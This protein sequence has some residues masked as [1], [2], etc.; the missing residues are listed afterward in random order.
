MNAPQTIGDP[1]SVHCPF[2]PKEKKEIWWFILGDEK[3]GIASNV[4]RHTSLTHNTE[5][6]MKF[7]APDK[8]GTYQLT[9]WILTDS[10]VGYNEKITLK[11]NVVKEST[12]KLDETTKKNIKD[13]DDE[14]ALL[15]EDD[16]DMNSDVD[17]DEI[18]DSEE[19]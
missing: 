12:V 9:L 18:S 17:S 14:N 13:E 7:R 11:F 4:M 15:S 10:Y 19:E 8:I 6:Q 3:K 5:I 2:F 1:I 16:L